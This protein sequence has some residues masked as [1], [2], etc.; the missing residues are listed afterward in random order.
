VTVNISPGT[1]DEFY[2]HVT[3]PDPDSDVEYFQSVTWLPEVPL[4]TP[5][6]AGT[7]DELTPLVRDVECCDADGDVA[8]QQKQLDQLRRY[9]RLLFEAAFGGIW[10][11]LLAAA[12]R[13]GTDYLEVA[14][15]GAA[16]DDHAALQALRW[17]ALYD[18][19]GF[20]AAQGTTYQGRDIYVGVVR[21]I[22]PSGAWP[23]NGA[24]E[25]T[26]LPKITHIPKVLFAVGSHLTDQDV[27]PGA[28]FMG[29]MRRLDRDGGSIR[30][31]LLES[32]T[33]AKLADE[34][35]TFK[36]DVLHLIGHGQRRS[37]GQV[38]VR[39][40]REP[41]GPDGLSA[42]RLLNIFAAAGHWPTMAV[43]SVCQTASPGIGAD[44]APG[45]APERV[46]AGSFAA[47][48]VAGNGVAGE[49]TARG[50]PVV[51]AM[52]GDIS[53]TACRL[54][55]QAL[56]TSIQHGIQLGKAA[57]LGRGAAFYGGPGP[58]SGHWVMPTLFLAD[59]VGEAARLVN[60]ARV[61]AARRRVEDLGL[62]MKQ[63]FCGRADFMT[64]ADRLLD[65]DDELNV[66]VAYTPDQYQSFGGTRL[67]QELG[68][69]AI[70]ADVLPVLLDLEGA[71]PKNLVDLTRGFETCINEIRLDLGFRER[72][73][74]A[75]AAA[76][77]DEDLVGLAK[78]IRSDLDALVED[79]PEDDPI[80]H[81]GAGQP[82]TI[83]LCRRVDTWIEVLDDLV[84]MLGPHGLRAGASRV[85]VVLTGADVHQ[86]K[87]ERETKQEG[88][89]WI[90][91][92]PLNRFSKARDEDILAYTWWLLNPPPNEPVYAPARGAS[93]GWRD[94]L[95]HTLEVQDAPLYPG[96][97]L[98]AWAKIAHDYFTPD[99]DDAMLASYAEV[100]LAGHAKVMP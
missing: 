8:S 63:V 61:V 75:V 40:R 31:R 86:L 15:W 81:R 10:P 82:R 48:L 13:A 12:V 14:V 100:M 41:D 28:E 90:Q 98:Y 7:V 44:S 27:R 43:L 54:F 71:P 23:G 29:I 5:L 51:V 38:E 39:I 16:D 73:S 78:A 84:K 58:A 4:V 6:A 2:L 42:D 70:R 56:T 55:T 57:A 77:A 85:P 53:D 46:S 21:L 67:L 72:A 32:A 47:R 45:A 19:T 94:L 34:L 37:D 93:D 76:T 17:E 60:T 83:L 24:A 49:G 87:T 50:V 26:G 36:P 68:A 52:G 95:R 74:R 1:G 96:R 22:A 33:G 69:R 89:T 80:R 9:G 66:L 64:A 79:L 91:F 97:A 30:A 35:K 65:G 92:L 99:N 25:G 20:V 11:E 3:V 18:G 88:P 62:A 59:R